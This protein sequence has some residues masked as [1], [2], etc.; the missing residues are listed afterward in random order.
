MLFVQIVVA[1]LGMIVMAA[2]VLFI[3][4]E[5]LTIFYTSARAQLEL[6]AIERQGGS[7]TS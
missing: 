6:M 7:I 5:R 2:E 3:G 1:L 4:G